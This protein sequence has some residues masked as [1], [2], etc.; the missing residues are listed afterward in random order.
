[1]GG[2]PFPVGT[3]TE[4]FADLVSADL[5]RG[6]PREVNGGSA[7]GIAFHSCGDHASIVTDAPA[8]RQD[9]TVARRDDDK[10]RGRFTKS[11]HTSHPPRQLP[12]AGYDPRYAQRGQPTQQRSGGFDPPTYHHIHPGQP[13]Q[14]AGKVTVTRT[15]VARSNEFARSVTR[16]VINASKAGG[17]EESGLTSLIWNQMLSYGTDA[18]IAVALATTVFFGASTHAQRG[19]VLLYLLITMAP[20]AVVAPVI[21]PALDRLQHG[22]RLAMAGTAFGRAVLAAI[23]AQ[24]SAELLVLY[25]CALGSLVLSKA[26]SVIRAAAAPRL[27]PPGMTL[28]EANA[29]LSIFSLGSGLVGGAFIGIVIKITGTSYAAGLWVTALAFCV[30]GYFALRLPKQIDAV[31]S[32]APQRTP[33]PEGIARV[34]FKRMQSWVQRGLV[35]PVI[36]ALQGQAMLR[37]LA[38]FLP[39]FLAFYI[40]TTYHGWTAAFSLGVILIGSG[41]GSFLGTGIGTRLKLAHPERVIMLCGAVAAAACLLT[42]ILFSIPFAVMCMVVSSATNG[43]G[44]IAMDAIIQRDVGESMRASVFAR[45]ET[46]LQL[47]WVAGAAVAVALPSTNGS[48]G[49]WVAGPIM[50]VSTAFVLLRHRAM[51]RS[52]ATRARPLPPGNVAPGHQRP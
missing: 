11:G 18:M 27:V 29:R 25:P 17:A 13:E 3:H 32:A 12:P 10:P 7:Y 40:E 6:S 52:S 50:A 42:A 19:N 30:C 51:R 8:L 15:I 48:L 20:F 37:F 45:S 47:T 41:A 16:R 21:G 36:T 44:K 31:S 24:H 33:R 23:M 46:F 14:A 26:Y 5:D 39:I 38:G 49:F 9:G 1:M 2:D 4:V 28:V 43:L 35:P 34:S 22:R